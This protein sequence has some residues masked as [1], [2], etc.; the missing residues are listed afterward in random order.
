M[1]FSAADTCIG[2]L[3]QLTGH[4]EGYKPG[5]PAESRFAAID[6][7]A[8]WWEKEGKAE[9]IKKHPE[10]AIVYG[11]KP[12]LSTVSASRPASRPAE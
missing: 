4:D 8:A 1:P 6:R 7:W 12:T 3:I 10:V 5:D 9:Y 11:R 2:A